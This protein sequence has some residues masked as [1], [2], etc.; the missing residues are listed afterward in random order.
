MAPAGGLAAVALVVVLAPGVVEDWQADLVTSR[1]PVS[2]LRLPDGS[3]AHLA[4]DTA[5]AFD[6]Q[7]GRRRVRLLRGEAF[8]EVAHGAPGAFTVEIGEGEVRDI[9]TKFDVNRLPNGTDIVVSEGSVALAGREDRQ[10][11]ILQR[12]DKGVI[13][14]GRTRG[15][16]AA[17]V[18]LALSWMSGRLVVQGA[19]V[20]DV[21]AALQRHTSRRI[22]VR[23]A[24]ARREVSASLPL[25]NV[26]ASLETVATAVGGRVLRAPLLIV[27]Y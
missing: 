26:D 9:G 8:F 15:V 22:F 25:T 21:V 13:A 6:F 3:T 12:G 19:T 16:E 20:E 2:V 27:I 1:D 7:P 24:L 18:D 17:D 14:G 11:T 5:V 4:A 10:L 23:G